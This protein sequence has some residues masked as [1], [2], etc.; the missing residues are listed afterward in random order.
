MTTS[1]RDKPPYDD[2]NKAE[3]ISAQPTTSKDKDLNEETSMK[4]R[5]CSICSYSGHN[6]AI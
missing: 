1:S 6:M 2:T 5:F 3:F 4:R